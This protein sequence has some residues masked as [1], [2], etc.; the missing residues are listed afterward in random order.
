L[1]GDDD[2]LLG[3]SVSKYSDNSKLALG[4]NGISIPTKL[5]LPSANAQEF[6]ALL[7]TENGVVYQDNYVVVNYKTSF[8]GS[9]GK[10]AMQFSTKGSALSNV[11]VSIP[12]T[13]NIFFNTSP[14]QYADHPSVVIQ[15][16][17]TGVG[18]EIPMVNLNF[19]Q[20][21]TYRNINFGL[22]LLANKWVAPVNM[23]QEAFD[24]YYK[25]YSDEENK[26]NYFRLDNF[27]ENP[28]PKNVPLSEVLK[29]VA[30][31]LT[32]GLNLKVIAP[33]DETNKIVNA[34]GQYVMKAEGSQNPTNL[35]I[36]VQVEAFEENVETIKLSL[37]GGANKEALINLYQ[38]VT[39][40]MAKP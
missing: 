8:Q 25:E 33:P 2:D 35:P 26:S 39:L 6:K 10:I 9:M 21:E 20:G 7:I 12:N 3:T 5:Q 4:K 1:L 15:C 22:P 23:P 37:R 11:V 14:V 36:M 13:N 18:G 16:I 40:Y 19:Y 24:K 28:A 17:N 31:L 38:L 32:N 34:V 27:I 30:A 29:K